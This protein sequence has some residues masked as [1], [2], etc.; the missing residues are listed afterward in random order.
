MIAFDFSALRADDTKNAGT[1]GT[2][3]TPSNDAAYSV[4]SVLKNVGT[5]GDKPGGD[6]V[7]SPVSP[8]RP[9]QVGTLKPSNG[10]VSPPSPLS[11]AKNTL[12]EKVEALAANQEGFGQDFHSIGAEGERPAQGLLTITTRAKAKPIRFVLSYEVDG[13]RATCIDA[14]SASLAEAVADLRRQHSGRV[15]CIWCDDK[16]V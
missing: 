2:L 13:R 4:P 6:G 7:L 9:Q 14:V 5:G 16:E 15:G 10:A 11:P 1:V 3:G 12:S 8:V